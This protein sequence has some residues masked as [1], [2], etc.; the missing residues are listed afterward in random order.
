MEILPK[1]LSA[2]DMRALKIGAVAVAVILLFV[3]S[4]SWLKN[5]RHMRK[6]LSEKR[7]ELKTIVSPEAKQAGLLAI[8][9]VFELPHTGGK[10][11]FLFRNKLKEQLN[12]AG[13]K[14]RPLEILA[15]RKSTSNVNY[16]LLRVK[17]SSEKCTFSQ[18]LNLLAV[19][20]ENPYLAGIEELNIKCDP[21]KREE[22]KLNIVVSTFVKL[23]D[24][25]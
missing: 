15:G 1:K 11:K 14:S 20:K 21:K 5:W 16:N 19:L 18:I 23:A 10:Q 22:F 12:K 2:K 24:N 6:S 9:P 3:I 17:C 13:I 25:E 8:V 7:A 4:S